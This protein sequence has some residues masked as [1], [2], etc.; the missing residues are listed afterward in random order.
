MATTKFK[1][2]AYDSTKNGSPFTDPSYVTVVSE[3]EGRKELGYPLLEIADYLNNFVGGNDTNISNI[4]T[5]ISSLKSKTDTTNKN[6]ST[7]ATNISS[8]Q[9]G[10]NTA[11]TNISKNASNITS[12][13]SGLNTTNSNVSKNASNITT[14]Q[15]GLATTNTNVSKNASDISS[16]KT[17]TDTINT[18]VTTNA[19][20]IKSLQ[21]SLATTN[22]NVST[23]A[24][25][26]TK[27]NN[28]LNSN[29]SSLNSAIQTN[30]N[31]INTNKNNI[32]TLTTNLNKFKGGSLGAFLT[33]KSSTDFDVSWSDITLSDIKEL[34]STVKSLVEAMNYIELL[35]PLEI[36]DS[37]TM[38]MFNDELPL[39]ASFDFK[40]N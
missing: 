6:V 27:L 1:F 31:N 26:I 12:L 21:T 23:N 37:E 39:L 9:S 16:L 30:T 24:S 17:K 34:I 25:N 14:L 22:S 32:S 38:L 5:D 10:L 40:E 7:N 20:S 29:V 15:N 8:L 3:T 33:K 28:E 4:E 18:N 2:G 36:D 35:A 19:N 11:N 13:Q